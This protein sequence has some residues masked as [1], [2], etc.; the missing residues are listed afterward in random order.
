MQLPGLFLRPVTPMGQLCPGGRVE[1]DRGCPV[2]AG[3]PVSLCP[4][5]LTTWLVS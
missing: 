3:T 2:V 5:G 1:V 4:Q